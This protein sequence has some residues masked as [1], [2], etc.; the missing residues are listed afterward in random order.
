MCSLESIQNTKHSQL[1]E[2]TKWFDIMGNWIT[3]ILSRSYCN[4]LNLHVSTKKHQDTACKPGSITC[5]LFIEIYGIPSCST[6]KMSQVDVRKKFCGQSFTFI[7]GMTFG[8]LSVTAYYPFFTIFA[9][10]KPCWC[11]RFL[12]LEHDC[13]QQNLPSGQKSRSGTNQGMGQD[14]LVQWE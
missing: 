10:T 11:Y 5:V 7:R 6:L 3:F 4:I 8:R 14:V 1:T 9:L 12:V 13:E 2:D